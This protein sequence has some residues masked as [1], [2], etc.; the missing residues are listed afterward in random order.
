M[1]AWVEDLRFAVRVLL[2]SPSF[3]VISVLTLALGICA[4]T[5]VFSV[6]KGVLLQPLAYPQPDQLVAIDE[7]NAGQSRVPI[8]YLNLSDWQRGVKCLRF[9]GHLSPRGS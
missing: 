7:S 1:N 8:S 3:T 9:D 5:V 6:V 2:K 4:N